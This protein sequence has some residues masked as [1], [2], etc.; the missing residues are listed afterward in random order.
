[1]KGKLNVDYQIDDNNEVIEKCRVDV[2]VDCLNEET[3]K[4][5]KNSLKQICS[6]VG[7]FIYTSIDKNE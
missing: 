4:C 6:D 3:I 1:M 7:N 2:Y 5:V